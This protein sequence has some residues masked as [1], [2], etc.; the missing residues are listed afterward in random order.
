MINEKVHSNKSG[1]ENYIP[2]IRSIVIFMG[3]MALV[4]FAQKDLTGSQ[5]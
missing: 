5:F 2:K 1:S 3:A 4:E